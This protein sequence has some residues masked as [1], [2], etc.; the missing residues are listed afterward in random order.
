MV[1]NDLGDLFGELQGLPEVA[2]DGIAPHK[3]GNLSELLMS[4]AVDLDYLGA[5]GSGPAACLG[6]GRGR[7]WRGRLIAG[8]MST[9]TYWEAWRAAGS[10]MIPAFPRP[11]LLTRGVPLGLPSQRNVVYVAG[12][13]GAALYVGS[14]TRGVTARVRE[15]V[16]HRTRAGW[17]E[18]WVIPLREGLT[19]ARV[20]LAEERVGAIVRPTENLRRP[21]R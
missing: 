4:R 14:T 18:L 2:R 15:H 21:G 5:Q 13:D 12:V 1:R 16:R 8:S 17:E 6:G 3:V 10:A 20:L 9:G 11:F 7:G 19:T